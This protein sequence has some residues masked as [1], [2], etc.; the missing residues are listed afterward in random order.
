MGALPEQTNANVQLVTGLQQQLESVTN[1]IR[2]DQDRLNSVE[3]QMSAL[4]SG[5]AADPGA[6]AAPAAPAAGLARIASLE[7]ALAAAR[8]RYTEQYPEVVRLKDELAKAQADARADATRPESDRL[9]SL[10]MDPSYRAM[11][12]EKSDIELRIAD[13]Q[14]RQQAIQQQIGM[15]RS[16]VDAAP[17][18]EQQL[19]TVQREYDLEK[20]NYSNLTSKLRDAQMNESL[21][22]NQGGERFTVLQHASLPAEP[23]SPNIPRVLVL[24]LLVG[25]CLGG[26]L[27]LGREYLDRAIYDSRS[28]SELELPILGEI[29]RIAPN[30]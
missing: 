27:A 16:R 10:R 24:V 23:F 4:T 21:E 6:A 5:A 25:A 15:Y 3:R 2:G 30:V 8:A 1:G 28:L 11:V 18:V 22:R 14:R 9:A 12:K 20:Q 29:P 19:G 7:A 17:R 26:G 13:G